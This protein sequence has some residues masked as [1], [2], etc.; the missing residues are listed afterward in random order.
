MTP[1]YKKLFGSIG[2]PELLIIFVVALVVIGPKLM[3]EIAKTLGKALRDFK[4][5][6]SDF[7]DTINLE[8]DYDLEPTE[9]EKSVTKKEEEKDS[10]RIDPGPRPETTDSPEPQKDSEGPGDAPT[11]E[12]TKST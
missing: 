4:R 3:P 2:I 12:R 9:T 1:R 6:T 8:T 10:N 5:A 7:Q 11:G